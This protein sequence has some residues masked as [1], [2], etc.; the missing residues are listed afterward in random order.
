VCWLVFVVFT[1]VAEQANNIWQ[2]I[3]HD[4]TNGQNGR[5]CQWDSRC[6]LPHVSGT[7]IVIEIKR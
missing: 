6:R 7:L 5:C 3:A 4:N 2:E 1:A